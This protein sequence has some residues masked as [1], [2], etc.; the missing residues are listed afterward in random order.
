MC[1]SSVLVLECPR[2]SHKVNVEKDYCG[3]FDHFGADLFFS[4]EAMRIGVNSSSFKLGLVLVTA[5]DPSVTGTIV[6]EL[7]LDSLNTQ[8]T[9]T[10]MKQQLHGTSTSG[11][12][13]LVRTLLATIKADL[14]RSPLSCPY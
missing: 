11:L 8:T 2:I 13:V 4:S 5:N 1:F 6:S 10:T 9:T 7:W 12:T 3:I 14:P